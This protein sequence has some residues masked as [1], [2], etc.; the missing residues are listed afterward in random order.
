MPTALIVLT[1]VWST[2]CELPLPDESA[3]D[4]DRCGKASVPATLR[5]QRNGGLA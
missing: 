5:P 1:L 4:T 2:S 3:A